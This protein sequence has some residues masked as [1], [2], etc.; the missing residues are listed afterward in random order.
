MS[1][2]LAGVPGKL[3]KLVTRLAPSGYTQ[4]LTDARLSKID[5]LDVSVLSRA[6]S[7]TALD[8]TTW[9]DAKAGYL[10]AAI[11]GVRI[12]PQANMIRD[13]SLSSSHS[14]S[15]PEHCGLAY[16]AGALTAGVYSELLS[17]TAGGYLWLAYCYRGAS[18]AS[19][20]LGL[21]ITIDGDAWDA[22]VD[23]ATT[24]QGQGFI[25]H[26][27]QSSGGYPIPMIARFDT[28]L[29]VEIASSVDQ[30]SG[31]ATAHVLYSLDI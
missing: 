14:F 19:G 3:A 25:A 22:V 29:K 31:R 4:T 12:K 6:P 1:L 2:F 7:S 5:Y 17:V 27:V 30:S 8:K 23:S 11:S 24:T 18:F 9:S 21:K 26:G 16:N 28:S 10:D 15:L 20:T 13:T